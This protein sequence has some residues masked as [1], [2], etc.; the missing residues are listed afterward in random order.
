M[1]LIITIRGEVTAPGDV[2]IAVDDRYVTLSKPGSRGGSGTSLTLPL[3]S[4]DEVNECVASVR[5]AIAQAGD[6]LTEPEP[7]PTSQ[8]E[9]KP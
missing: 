4:W 7:E 9:D 5:R 6:L 8:A 3:A 2:R 1:K